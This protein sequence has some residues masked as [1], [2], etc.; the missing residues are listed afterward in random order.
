MLS[1]VQVAVHPAALQHHD[2]GP[3]A[4]HGS[5][6]F[7]VIG[8]AVVAHAL[9]VEVQVRVVASIQHAARAGEGLAHVPALPPENWYERT[10]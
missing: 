4:K 10:R 8:A 7:L 9:G 2:P 1:V 6:G 5:G 3:V